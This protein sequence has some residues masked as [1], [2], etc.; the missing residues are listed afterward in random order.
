M[1]V[2]CAW[3]GKEVNKPPIDVKRYKNHFCGNECKHLWLSRNKKKYN[4]DYCGKEILIKHYIYQEL[5][6]GKRENIFCGRKCSGKWISDNRIG[7][8]HPRFTQ[9]EN[10]C[11]MCGNKFYVKKS[12]SEKIVFCSYECREKSWEK[13][14]RRIEKC[15]ECGSEVST[16][17]SDPR[18]RFF[19]GKECNKIYFK[20]EKDRVHPKRECVICGKTYRVSHSSRYNSNVTCSRKCYDIWFKE[21]SNRE[22]VKKKFIKMMATAKRKGSLTKPEKIVLKCLRDN[23][24]KFVPQYPIENGRFIVDFFLPE[25]QIFLEVFGDYWHSNPNKYGDTKDLKPL[26]KKQLSI[27]ERDKIKIKYFN[28]RNLNLKIIW[29]TDIYKNVQEQIDKLLA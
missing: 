27:K 28:D 9:V 26:N 14:N 7:Q 19:C 1:I 10:I 22:D 16:H 13:N 29:E 2:N 23:N 15:T 24:I 4:C 8:N 20:K 12:H 6:D 25:L 18:T 17:L 21:Y 11:P 5:I 3:C